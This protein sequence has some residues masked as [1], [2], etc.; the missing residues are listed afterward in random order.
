M[1]KKRIIACLDVKNGEV[2]KGINFKGHEKVGDI[3]MLAKEY[4]DQGIDELVFY[5]I[6]ASCENRVVSKE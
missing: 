1:I 4:S 2:I 6:S 5:D 3:V